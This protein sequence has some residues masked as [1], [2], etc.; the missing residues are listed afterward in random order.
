MRQ[1]CVVES[2]DM[3]FRAT[4]VEPEL[5]DFKLRVAA[6]AEPALPAEDAPDALLRFEPS[7]CRRTDAPL[8][9]RQ[10][11]EEPLSRVPLLSRPTTAEPLS[12]TPSPCG[13]GALRGSQK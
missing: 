13:P 11:R 2:S 4:I 1:H 3:H 6:P 5:H 7:Q 12:R 9:W 8:V 10:T